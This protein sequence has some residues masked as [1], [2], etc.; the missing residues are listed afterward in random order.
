VAA[1]SCA[2]VRVKG[3]RRRV[4][5]PTAPSVRTA[6]APPALQQAR[7]LAAIWVLAFAIRCLYLWQIA[8]APFY[9]LRLGDADAYDAWARRIAAG[10]WIGQG[11]FYQAPLY[12][13]L[14]ALLYRTLG[15]GVTIVRIVQALLGATSCALLA[16]AAASFAGEKRAV[17]AGALLAVYP[18][19]IFLDGLLEKSSFVTFFTVLLLWLVSKPQADMSVRRWLGAGAALGLLTLTRENALLL[20]LPLL[21]WIVLASMPRRA[22]SRAAAALAA[23]CL[24]ILLPVGV[25]NLVAGGGFHLTTAQFGPN[26]YI[27]NHAGASGTYDAL[28]VGHGSAA[29]E[30]ED[31]RRLA[32]RGAG[33]PLTASEVSAFWS[34]RAW[35]DIRS[36]PMAWIRLLA[37][38]AALT[39]NAAEIADTETLDVYAEWSTLLRALRPF[40]FGVLLGLA[41]LGA[42]LTASSWRHLWLLYAVATTY[43]ASVVL[44]YV[45]ARYRFPIAPVLTMLAATGV[46]QAARL[47]RGRQVRGLVPALAAAAGAVVLAHLPLENARAS[48]AMH[49]ADIG[50]AMAKDPNRASQAMEFY[51]RA[52]SEAPENPA[53]QFGVGTLLARMGRPSDAIAH[54]ES[55]VHAWPEYAEARYNLGLALAAV[56]RRQESAQQLQ[57]SVRLRPDDVEA[58]LALAKVMIGL[59]RP[60]LALAQYDDT[61]GRQADNV[62]ALVGSG[63]ALTQLGRPRDAI[64]RYQRAL[65]LSP[66]DVEAH[67]NLGYTLATEGRIDEALPHFERA[68]ALNPND[69]NARRNLEQAK[70]I[71]NNR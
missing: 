53:A 65:T 29:D 57:E 5:P 41:A 36:Q 42:V 1:F 19:A 50:A 49:Y 25:R 4:S 20:M 26:F 60:D 35:S 28:T 56:G 39:F 45:F 30:Q 11:V 69:A 68:L 13:Y 21:L 15:D 55:A 71:R 27:G 34:N 9:D 61:L 33:R 8:H 66:D 10:D 2:G 17:I 3:A 62:K 52:L 24:A 54:Y 51:Q 64:E 38:K 6:S 70:R 59:Q 67:N 23:G 44:F 58:Q 47:A 22:R 48:R 32:E 40:D 37:R 31:A 63:V 12:P 16:A 43:A 46:V 14:L 7:V 18:P